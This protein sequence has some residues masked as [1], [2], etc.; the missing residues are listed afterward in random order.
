MT[1]TVART[2]TVGYVDMNTAYRTVRG[3]PVGIMMKFIRH[4]GRTQLTVTNKQTN[5]QTTG[6]QTDTIK[7]K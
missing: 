6:R 2:G 7:T 1:D 5:K 3:R 4:T